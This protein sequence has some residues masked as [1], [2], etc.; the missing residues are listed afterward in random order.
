MI[1]TLLLITS[2]IF[3]VTATRAVSGQCISITV[4]LV[5]PER[6]RVRQ[7]ARDD[8]KLGATFEQADGANKSIVYRT[9]C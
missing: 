1:R 6:G 7:T 9:H 5:P 2:S 4:G 3:D 8:W